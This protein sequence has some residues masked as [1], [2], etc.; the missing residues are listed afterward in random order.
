MRHETFEAS[1]YRTKLAMWQHL[2]PSI[3]VLNNQSAEPVHVAP[4]LGDVIKR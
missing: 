2:E 3:R 1:D 4:T